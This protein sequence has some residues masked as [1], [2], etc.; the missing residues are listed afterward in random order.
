[1][2]LDHCVVCFRRCR[3]LDVVM[4]WAFVE[5]NRNHGLQM[6]GTLGYFTRITSD[7]RELHA[8][9][10]SNSPDSCHA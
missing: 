7:R 1:M 9:S 5:K 8:R 2:H 4:P 6:K 10:S 3:T